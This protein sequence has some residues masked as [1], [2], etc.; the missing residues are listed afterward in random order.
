VLNTY[1][2][3]RLTAR[4]DEYLTLALGLAE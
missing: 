4:T 3:V 2:L 1:G